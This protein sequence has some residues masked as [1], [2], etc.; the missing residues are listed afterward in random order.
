MSVNFAVIEMLT[1]LKSILWFHKLPHCNEGSS[2]AK[3][4]NLEFV[5]YYSQGVPQARLP[6]LQL[7]TTLDLQASTSTVMVRVNE[8]T[9]LVL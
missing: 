2:K 7:L 1:H 9:L 3:V 4:K 8:L 5:V 6:C